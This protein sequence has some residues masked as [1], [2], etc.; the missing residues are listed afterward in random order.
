MINRLN[1]YLRDHN[2]SLDSEQIEKFVEYNR[3]LIEYNSKINLTTIT[4][5]LEVT[6]KHFFDSL[7][8]AFYLDLEGKSIIDIG[9]GAGFPGIPLKI[10]FPEIQLTLLDSLQKRIKFLGVVADSLELDGVKLIHG[11]AEELAHDAA[12]REQY[13]LAIARAVARL[14]VLAELTLPFVKVGGSLL[15]M[16]ASKAEEEL[17]EATNAIRK[18]G[19]QARDIYTLEL[20]EDS[21]ERNLI[22]IDKLA[23]TPKTYPRR[24]GEPAR[25]PLT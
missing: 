6:I 8:P 22:L 4:M 5:P 21:G 25:R 24:P 20:P 7:T 13:D 9:A 18:L 14:N 11:R 23:W 1:D 16:K 2:I 10:L 17:S 19:G 15:A 3:L 12:H